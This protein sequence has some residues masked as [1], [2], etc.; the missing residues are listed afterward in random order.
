MRP[1]FAILVSLCL[2]LQPSFRE[3]PISDERFRIGEFPVF[4]ACALAVISPWSS[5]HRHFHVFSSGVKFARALASGIS[6]SSLPLSYVTPLLIML[7]NTTLPPESVVL[8]AATIPPKSPKRTRPHAP[9]NPD[10]GTVGR[11]IEIVSQGGDNVELKRKLRAYSTTTGKSTNSETSSFPLGRAYAQPVQIDLPL[12]PVGTSV[13][14]TPVKTL[15]GRYYFRLEAPQSKPFLIRI[16]HSSPYVEIIPS[17]EVGLIADHIEALVGGLSSAGLTRDLDHLTFTMNGTKTTK[18]SEFAFGPY[19]MVLAGAS[20]QGDF[21]IHVVRE[22]TGSLSIQ[23]TDQQGSLWHRALI[24]YA[25]Y[26][27]PTEKRRRTRELTGRAA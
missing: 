20:A 23:V 4:S 22:E 17:V 24:G 10:M 7:V 2:F 3:R 13:Q 8:L 21:T 16:A 27:V 15:S 6:Q 19:A 26:F 5:N 1:S 14:C 12:V 25:P 11:Y 9:D 18:G